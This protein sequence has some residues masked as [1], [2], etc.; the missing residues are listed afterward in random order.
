MFAQPK[1]AELDVTIAANEQVIRFKVTV[2]I[3]QLMHR[4]NS[5]DSF[6]DVKPALIF[7]Q[8]ILFHQQS[9]QIA[10]LEKL[11]HQVEVL[12]ILERA[13]EFDNPRILCNGKNISL[14]PNVSNLVLVNHFCLFHLLDSHYLTR[15]LVFAHPH[16]T[17]SSS[18]YDL[19]R[20]EVFDTYLCSSTT[21]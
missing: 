16:F 2:D 10:S 4:L 6:S 20:L 5:E 13:F 9:H 12:F 17:E 15:F 21:L 3:V 18:T 19:E 7:T 11:H 8:D 1:I 14:G